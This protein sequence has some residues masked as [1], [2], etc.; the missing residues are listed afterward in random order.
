MTDAKQIQTLGK[1]FLPLGRQ[2]EF[3]SSAKRESNFFCETMDA[4][5]PREPSR[6]EGETFYLD[7]FQG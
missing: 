5:G 4:N 2:W 6:F 1:A 3:G 7:V